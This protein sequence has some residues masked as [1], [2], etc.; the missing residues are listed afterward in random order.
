MGE[1]PAGGAAN[2]SAAVFGTGARLGHGTG[3]WWH[4]PDDLLDK[5][6]EG[7]PVPRLQALV[8]L[9]REAEAG[10]PLGWDMLDELCALQERLP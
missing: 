8:G 4:T 6:N 1:Q 5:M 2:A 3:W 9:V 7:V 10:R